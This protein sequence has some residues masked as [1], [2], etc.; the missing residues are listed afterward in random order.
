LIWK[1]TISEIIMKILGFSTAV[2][3]FTITS[4]TYEL[5]T[6]DS[7]GVDSIT[8]TDSLESPGTSINGLAWGGGNLWAVDATSKTIFR[9]DVSTGEILDSFECSSIPPRQ[10]ATGLAYNEERALIYLGLDDG[11]GL[12]YVNSYT[13]EGAFMG[14]TGMCGS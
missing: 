8:V 12:G 5:N 4:W 11:W 1:N 14:S 10:S 7:A 3:F 6:S 2:A 13:H 9:M